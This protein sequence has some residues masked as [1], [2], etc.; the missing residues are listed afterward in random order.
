MEGNVN[1]TVD[2][3]LL[4]YSSCCRPISAWV[5]FCKT[6]IIFNVIAES[7]NVVSELT[8]CLLYGNTT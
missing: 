3:D 5:L 2:G 4:R 7:S 1:H 6:I 8:V